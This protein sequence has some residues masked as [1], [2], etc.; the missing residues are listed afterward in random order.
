MPQDRTF[1]ALRRKLEA[2]ELEHL[3]TLVAQ[4][5]DRIE[6]LEEDVDALQRN[7]EFWE[8]HAHDLMRD[9]AD[10]GETVGITQDGEIGVVAMQDD[11]LIERRGQ[12]V[13]SII[14]ARAHS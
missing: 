5:R 6:R 3:R 9:V 4:Q 1:T 14:I 8:R 12:P 13:E 10:M 2:W 11:P 7:A